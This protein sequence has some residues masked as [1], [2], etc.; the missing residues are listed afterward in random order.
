MKAS[1]AKLPSEIAKENLDRAQLK[2][3]ALSLFMVAVIASL[4]VFTF[5]GERGAISLYRSW[6]KTRQLDVELRA[7]EEHNGKKRQ[8][9]A[10]LAHDPKAVEKVVREELDMLRPGEIMFVLPHD[11]AKPQVVAPKPDAAAP[12]TPSRRH[13][14]RPR[15]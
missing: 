11:S 14:P 8:E 4:F 5:T 1:S 12:A 3:K 13:R 10:R 6:Q 15:R 7:L 9:N 2:R